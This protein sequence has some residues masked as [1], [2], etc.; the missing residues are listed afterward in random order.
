MSSLDKD[1][2]QGGPPGRH[3]IGDRLRAAREKRGRTLRDVSSA[4]SISESMLSQIE[5]NRVSPAIDTL[6]RI[7]DAL[8]LDVDYVFA[9]YRKDRRVQVVRKAERKRVDVQGVVYS[10]LSCPPPG[11]ADEGIEAFLLEIPPGGR[12]GS[13]EYGHVGKELGILLEGRAVFALGGRRWELEAGDSIAFG[14]DSPH[15]LENAGDG[16]LRA[17]WILTPPRHLFNTEG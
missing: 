16:P 12:K 9:D 14:S 3:F 6:L 17:Y 15:V 8:D 5:R 11:A 2:P 13:D 7:C 1:D 10:Q 4:A